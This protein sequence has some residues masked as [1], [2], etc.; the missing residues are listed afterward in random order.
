MKVLNIVLALLF[1]L[2]AYFQLNDPDPFLWVT[3]YI[4]VAAI[5]AFAA[6]GK[7]NRW[8]LLIGLLGLSIY[9]G[10]LLPDFITWLKDG[11]PTI[12]GSM[13]AESKYI[14]LVREFLGLLILIV[15]LLWQYYRMWKHKKTAI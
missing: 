7:Y 2:F 10:L 15:V 11:M 14:E 4:I 5:C 3:I 6:F 9:F 13:K 12:T 8:V 1:T